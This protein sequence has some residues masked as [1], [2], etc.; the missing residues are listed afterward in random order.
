MVLIG[1]GL[2][3]AVAVFAFKFAWQRKRT[4]Y[5][6]IFFGLAAANA[7]LVATNYAMGSELG[8]PVAL[9]ML[10]AIAILIVASGVRLRKPVAI[11][12]GR[13][14]ADGVAS[15]SNM[16]LAGAAL[17]ALLGAV[18]GTVAFAVFLPIDAETRAVTAL[19]AFP[20]LWAG[21]HAWTLAAQHSRRAL[22]A[23]AVL[24]IG[25]LGLTALT[26]LQ[27]GAI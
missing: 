12:E 23:S 24:G 3:M 22:A 19:L 10:A 20:L 9:L 18:G 27:S 26:I 5:A 14:R 7:G 16:R 21:L 15:L 4:V 11:R 6:L 8:I 13:E 17:T 2:A 25:G 1:V